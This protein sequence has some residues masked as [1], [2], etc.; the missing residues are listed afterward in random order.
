MNVGALFDFAVSGM[1]RLNKTGQL[2]GSESGIAMMGRLRDGLSGTGILEVNIG[3][4]GVSS[5]FGMGGIDVGGAVYDLAKRGIDY[6]MMNLMLSGDKRDV[7]IQNYGW[8]DWTAENTSMRITSGLDELVFSNEAGFM[9]LTVSNGKGGRTITI[10][11]SGDVNLDAIRLQHESHRDGVVTAGNAQET[12][13]A[14][15]AHTQMAERMLNGDLS[16]QYDAYLDRD[17]AV[18]QYAKATG[19]MG[20]FNAYVDGV[21][22]SSDDYWLT[23]L[24]K[25]RNG[26]VR[27]MVE[28]EEGDTIEDL[29]ERLFGKEEDD[30]I[31]RQLKRQ[32]IN[33][34]TAQSSNTLD[35]SNYIT[36]NSDYSRMN[37]VFNASGAADF[38]QEL[39]GSD[40]S[41][42]EFKDWTV[43][44]VA[45]AI[46]F[47]SHRVIGY[48]HNEAILDGRLPGDTA[49]AFDAFSIAASL[50][51][52][53]DNDTVKGIE[54]FYDR[55]NTG[56]NLSYVIEILFHENFHNHQYDAI[57]NGAM[58][59]VPFLFRY[60]FEV[61]SSGNY[62]SLAGYPKTL[63]MT[64]ESIIQDPVKMYNVTPLGV[65]ER[66]TFDTRA[67]A[68]AY[69]ATPRYYEWFNNTYKR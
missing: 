1:A 36:A 23:R 39:L 20:L 29:A 41:N 19:N 48:S 46:P 3:S 13:R 69:Y 67:D 59:T 49:M 52:G 17:I 62:D 40:F 53:I 50:G 61:G 9:G 21:Y 16:I 27:F 56:R 51:F 63:N 18:Y 43:L 31:T 45:Q 66:T 22:D 60:L 7:A 6:S 35:L 47:S 65:R 38:L 25:D 42:T 24:V 55:Y 14:T 11:G 68:F 5:Q 37:Y 2:A 8:G 4:K 26:V 15:L 12:Q 58:G 28:K 32:F 54:S 33:E 64:L 57:G 10:Q 44:A 30:L 34:M